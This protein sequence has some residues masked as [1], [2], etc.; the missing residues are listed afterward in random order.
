MDVFYLALHYLAIFL[1][2]IL[3]VLTHHFRVFDYSVCL[4]SFIIILNYDS[5]IFT[6]KSGQSVIKKKKKQNF[7]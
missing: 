3:C 5:K 2:P 4:C 1:K 7:L 6:A